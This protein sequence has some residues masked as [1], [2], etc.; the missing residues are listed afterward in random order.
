MPVPEAP[1]DLPGRL[2]AAQLAS[3]IDVALAGWDGVEP[4]WIFGYGSLIWNPD[5]E[6]DRRLLARVHGYHRRLCLWS[7]VNRGT[8]D[9]PGLVAGLDRGGSCAGVAYRI[10]PADVLSRIRAALAARDVARF[11]HAALAHMPPGRRLAGAGTGVRGA[12]ETLRITPGK[13]SEAEIV[14]GYTR[15]SCGRYGS[16]LD[17]LVNCIVS[18]RE[19]GLRDP[20]FEKIARHAGVDAA[21]LHR[22]SPATLAGGTYN[23]SMTLADLRVE[24]ARAALDEAHADVDPLRQFARWWDEAVAAQVREGNAMTLAT[25][26]ADGRPSRAHRAVE[27]LRRRGLRIFYQLSEP[28]RSRAGCQSARLVCCFSGPSSNARFGSKAMS[29][30]SPNTNPTNI[31]AAARWRAAS[32]LGPRRRAK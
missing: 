23:T 6:F 18:L 24:Y 26:D 11:L 29:R 8:M 16:S 12:T 9:C 28:Q 10:R 25:A 20:H 22:T 14:E 4:V 3:S 19:H 31:F 13:L 2:S 1:A 30:G 27:R 21:L 17:Y 32:V 15:G 7:R 5:L